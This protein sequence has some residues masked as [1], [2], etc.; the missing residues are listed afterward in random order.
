MHRSTRAV[1]LAAALLLTV[2]LSGFALAA[3]GGTSATEAQAQAAP[4]GMPQAN[5]RMGD[6]SAMIAQQLDALVADGT[7][8]G[9]QQTAVSAAIKASLPA[10]SGGTPQGAPPSPGVQ[11]SAGAQPSRPG[12]MFSAALDALVEKGTITAVQQT[13]IEAALTQGMPGAPGGA[14]ATPAAGV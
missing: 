9:D 12:A 3:C 14:A 8:T 13:A 4:S 1:V 2:G 11:P 5:G 7:I 6:P 10:G